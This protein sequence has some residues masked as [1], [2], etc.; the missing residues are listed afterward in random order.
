MFR[1]QPVYYVGKIVGSVL[2]I[3]GASAHLALKA[4]IYQQIYVCLVVLLVLH[5]KGLPPIVF[6]VCQEYY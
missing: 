1:H 2:P 5:A 4:A 3:I 6:N